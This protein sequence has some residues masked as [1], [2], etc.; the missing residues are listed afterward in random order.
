MPK[1]SLK[2][3]LSRDEIVV[4]PGVYDGLSALVADR[5]NFAALYLSGY[6]VSASWLAQPDAGFLG[7][8]DMEARVRSICAV[9]Q[10]PLIADADTGFGGLANVAH[11]VLGYECA[12]AAGIQLEDQEFPKRC[13]H[14]KNRRVV[15]QKDAVAKIKLACE[16][17]N[18]TEF[19]IVARTDARASLGLDAA[20]RRADAFLS[21]GADILFVESPES[22]EEL[23][24]IGARFKGA[25]MLANM[26]AG[27]RTPLM[28]A[29][30]LQGLG[31]SIA[32]FPVL[33][34]AAAASA[35]ETAYTQLQV[36]G[37]A[38]SASMPQIDFDA[39]NTLVG[40][41]RV[42]ELDER[43]AASKTDD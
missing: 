4:A 33:G 29:A 19:L 20:L 31:Y 30:D 26:V 35:L 37:D 8:A 42:W 10:T 38:R 15:D 5:M 41:E 9:T 2:A 40:F 34:L 23:A 6:G 7:Y 14:T 3:V 39:L 43:F 28:S 11:T 21:V 13:G 36:S 22:E 32:I 18:S 17:R 25:P 12:G 16:T 24:A 27:G 1:M